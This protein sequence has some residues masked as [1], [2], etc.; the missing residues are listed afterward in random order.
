M[1]KIFLCVRISYFAMSYYYVNIVPVTI[2]IENIDQKKNYGSHNIAYGYNDVH[3]IQDMEI[4][5]S[6]CTT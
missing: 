1:S 4:Q 5:V 2:F 3:K 6:H